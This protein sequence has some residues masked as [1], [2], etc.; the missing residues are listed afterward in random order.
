MAGSIKSVTPLSIS[1]F[2][3]DEVEKTL[4]LLSITERS[5]LGSN[6]IPESKL[7]TQFRDFCLKRS[8]ASNP[9]L[10]VELTAYTPG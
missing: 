3:H 9:S 6:N 5:Q 2:N 1:S 10:D 7:W 8:L 4:S